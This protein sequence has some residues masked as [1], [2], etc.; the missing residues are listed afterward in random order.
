MLFNLTISVV[1]FQTDKFEIESVVKTVF[2]SPL[3]I[4]LYFIDNSPTNILKEVISVNEN[5]EYIHT[6]KNIGFGSAHNVAINIAN[7]I[8]E[9]HLILNADVIFEADILEKMYLFMK[10]NKEVGLLAPKI[11]NPDGSIQYS[12]KLLPTPV[13]LIV[14]R[15]LPIKSVQNYFNYLYEIKF[16]NFDRIINIP[17]VMGC[18]MFI[19]CKVFEQVQGFDERFFMY[20]EDIDLTRRIH[21]NFKTLYYPKLT[22][23]HKH[24]RGSYSNYKLLYYHVTSMIKYFNKWG[25]FFDKERREINKKILSQFEE[26]KNE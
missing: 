8:S 22:I 24:G 13:N 18:F 15:F 16:F 11:L 26:G 17:Y 19:N 5:V 14:R 3:K 25:W 1:L 2:G 10:E 4:K 20:P 21:K 9:F 7:K 12:A 23:I 6:G